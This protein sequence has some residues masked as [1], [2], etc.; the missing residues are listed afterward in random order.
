MKPRILISPDS[1]SWAGLAAEAIGQSISE[2]ISARGTCS[3][4]LTGGKVAEK[5]YSYCA[6][7]SALPLKNICFY[8][9]DERCVSP[10]HAES[11]Y[12]MAM[13]TLFAKGVPSGCSI[14]RMAAENPDQEETVRV[15]ERLIPEK[16][17]V[18]LLGMGGDGHIAS[19]F[20]GS[21]T[22]LQQGR[23]VVPATGP[24][25]PYQRLT[26]TP[27]VITSARKVFLLTTGK[28]KGKILAEALKSESDFMSLPVRLT[29]SGTWILDAEA[30]SQLQK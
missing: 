30:G 23:S 2:T 8:F 28:M 26:I 7:T 20:P 9:G 12:A 6:Q 25:A 11:N 15:Y 17:D 22:L 10:D 3:L 5:F 24:K 29:L 21:S 16:I 18:L 19:L 14:A 13:K 4:M 1:K 27:S